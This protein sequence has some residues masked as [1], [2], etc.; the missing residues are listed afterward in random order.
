MIFKKDKLSNN[1]TIRP[2][3]LERPVPSDEEVK[4]FEQALKR[5][6]KKEELDDNL[7]EI[8]R[9]SRGDLVD[10]SKMNRNKKSLFVTILKRVF[11]LAVI[12][13]L[14]YGFYFYFFNQPL[15]TSAVELSV[16]AP[17]TIKAG[18]EFA[19]K[20]KYKN[21]GKYLLNSVK[22]E[23]KYPDNFIPSQVNFGGENLISNSESKNYFDLPPVSIGEEVEISV[24]GK[25]ISKKDTHSTLFANLTYEPGDFSSEFKKESFASVLVN[26]LGFD[27]DFDY[28][29]AVLV[30]DASEV[31][32]IFSSVK[33]NF[34]DDFELSFLFPE[35]IIILDSS[36]T[37]TASSSLNIS[38]TSSL[39]WQVSGLSS[40]TDKYLLP[41][42]Y[43]VNKKVS[44]SQ[45]IIIRLSKK[46]EDGKTYVFA[47]KIIQLNVMNSNLNLTLTSNDSKN[48]NTV[49][50]GDTIN[51]SLNYTNKS[52]GHLNDVIL[53]AV[54]RG[55][56]LDWTTLKDNHNG[57]VSGN[58]I[59]WTKENIPDLEDLA[60]NE[61]GEINFSIKVKPY[62]DDDLG[63]SLEIQ[64]Y[65]QFNINNKQIG[66][67]DSKSN[68]IITKINSDLRLNEKI[69]YFDEN[70]LPVGSG[71]FPPKVGQRTTLK[72]YWQ[73][74][75]NLHELSN[76]TVVTK[77]PDYIFFEGGEK[78]SV[79]GIS[80]D[81]ESRS[82]IWNIG[83]LPVSTYRAQASFSIGFV[84]TERQRNTLLV[85]IS[86][87]TV[88]ATDQ[89]TKSFIEKKMGAKTSKLEDDSIAG[90]NNSGL[91]E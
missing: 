13:S 16:S 8:Y 48:D 22:L 86:D 89:D 38:K 67:S 18:E 72:V 27:V 34:L 44:D 52:D 53:M 79:G 73:I 47:E 78:T 82:V 39:F 71:P 55:D 33:E 19:Y 10:V 28:A 70:N 69:L 7:S 81:S 5:G 36:K 88:S 63:K 62:T 32:L 24:V 76:A 46:A 6:S 58:T 80:F 45:E 43:K 31:N 14:A 87:S 30:G 84:P 11:V 57:K 90:F 17:E 9:D 23:L 4:V 75:N 15:D 3:F 26:D 74:D 50:F 41:I 68:N 35:N 91:V 40:T 83:N 2:V 29:N 64:S 59:V 65:A 25:I 42:S 21:S 60:P 85:L 77:L 37:E 54:L 51:Y 12:C 20:I 56:F 66:A 61:E 1:K 49:N